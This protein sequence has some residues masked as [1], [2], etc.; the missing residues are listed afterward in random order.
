MISEKDLQEA[1]GLSDEQIKKA[2]RKVIGN[3]PQVR[4]TL[5]DILSE[6]ANSS[7]N[8]VTLKRVGEVGGEILYTVVAA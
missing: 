4:E 7:Q 1:L 3:S 6:Q 5:E 8:A 2:I